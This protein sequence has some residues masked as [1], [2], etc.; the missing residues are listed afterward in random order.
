MG[1]Q[2]TSVP[3]VEV[4]L[5]EGFKDGCPL[6]GNSMTETCAGFNAQDLLEETK[7]GDQFLL[8]VIMLTE[9]EL[10]ALPEF[11]GF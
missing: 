1:E 9:E 3:C 8:T 11:D 2:Q 4:T 6:Y 5:I 10:A 7:E